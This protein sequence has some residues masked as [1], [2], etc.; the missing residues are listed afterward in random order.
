MEKT[1]PANGQ[2]H[3]VMGILAHVDAGK[4]TL[5]EYLLTLA[6]VLRAPGRVDDGSTALDTDPLEKERGITI[7]ASEASFD[8][9]GARFTLL[10]TPGHVDFSPEA[11][12]IIP[13]LDLAVLLISG[14][15]GV[16]AHTETLWQ[17]L[18]HYHVPTVIFVSKMDRP[19]TDRAALMRRIRERLGEECVDFTDDP[20]AEEIALCGEDVLE[21][22]LESGSV[23]DEDITQL[24]ASRR[25]FP[26]FFG[27][28]LAQ[29]GADRMLKELARWAPESVFGE[30]FGARVYRISRDPSGARLTHVRL[31]GGSLSAREELVYH[32]A[33]GERREKVTQIRLYTGAQFEQTDCVY[34]GETAALTGLSSTYP[35]Q[36]LGA[37][38]QSRPPVLAPSLSYALR[39]PPEVS[40]YEAMPRLRELAEEEPT[41]SLHWQEDTGEIRFSLM[42][43]IQIQVLTELI[44]RRFGWEVTFDEGRILYRET[45]AAP[46]YGVGHFEPLRHYAEVLLML[47][48]LPAG[49]GIELD[50][51]CPEDKLER[52]WQ[53]L[54][55][56]NLADKQHVGVL[57]GAPL[58]DV[59]IT[60]IAGRAHE[61]HTEGGDFRQAACRAVRQGLMEAENV[62]LE[63]CYSYSLRVPAAQLGRAA[64]DIRAMHGTVSAPEA[65]GEMMRLT[66]KAPVSGMRDYS[67]TLAA[68]TGGRGSLSLTPGG[69][70]P[71]Y[72]AQEIIREI[73][74]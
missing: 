35:G 68:Y 60:L 61:K 30:A 10:D 51:R 2:K 31:T 38:G 1:T 73:G 14:T 24:V 42:G 39:L 44:R 13:V 57:T 43:E 25:L 21:R 59:R 41:F 28:G 20:D 46:S 33:G 64:G 26:C 45:I 54:I 19:D 12:R 4:T 11:E 6:G 16:Q 34:A 67:R 65:E 69:Y 71:A 8:C 49:S 9:A 18:A 22:F 5:S 17:L 53:R 52:N 29:T 48:P 70:E 7:Y 62:L 36:V 37:G 58:T 56:S 50:T 47:T 63:P 74:Y 3:I 27:S 40:P 66:G 23:S 15:D 32:A 72:N 55:L